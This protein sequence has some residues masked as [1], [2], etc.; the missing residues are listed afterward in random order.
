MRLIP[1]IALASTLALAACNQ[2]APPADNVATDDMAATTGND[3]MADPAMNGAANGAAPA[4]NFAGGDG[5]ALGSVT[6]ADSPAGL[7]LT[8][9]GSGMPGGVHG[10]HL[11]AVGKCDGP[12]FESA[13]A[14]F[15]PDSKMHGKKNPQGPHQG[16]LPNISV[17]PNGSATDKL[18]AAGVTMASLQD[19]DGTALVI[20]A[21]ADDYKTDPSGDSGDRIA[22]T[23][24]AAPR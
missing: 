19:A 24:V 2:A 18:T 23:V 10:V 16:D 20:H 17:G 14:H 6:A 9:A 22:C 8:L 7:V 3:M 4:M 1:A 21:K 15:N 13:G 12:K 11:H 5:T